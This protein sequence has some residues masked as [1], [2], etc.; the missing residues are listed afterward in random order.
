MN[1]CAAYECLCSNNRALINSIGSGGGF[2]VSFTLADLY[3]LRG[4]LHAAL[5]AYSDAAMHRP[6]NPG[7][8]VNAGNLLLFLYERAQDKQAAAQVRMLNDAR[9]A[10]ITALRLQPTL[11]SSHCGMAVVEQLTSASPSPH[12]ALRT[13]HQHLCAGTGRLDPRVVVLEHTQ[14]LEQVLEHTQHR[15]RLGWQAYDQHV[16]WDEL[17]MA[18]VNEQALG[19][20]DC[21]GALGLAEAHSLF[22]ERDFASAITAIRCALFAVKSESSGHEKHVEYSAQGIQVPARGSQ[23]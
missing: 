15:H 5:S 9:R 21:R 2:A 11:Q 12:S 4:K 18:A 6:Q 23:R 10:Y 16:S 14:V 3:V 7:P 8:L 20:H 19:R 1:A 17:W 22:H 13:L